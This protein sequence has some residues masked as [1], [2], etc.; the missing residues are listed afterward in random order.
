[1]VFIPYSEENMIL[2]T[3]PK[4]KRGDHFKTFSVVE[5][6]TLIDWQL[7]ELSYRLN[8]K[9]VDNSIRTCILILDSNT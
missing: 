6:V 7:T 8:N 5:A 4:I 1:M 2:R 9:F 3:E